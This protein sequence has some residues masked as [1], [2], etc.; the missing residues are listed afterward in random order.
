MFNAAPATTSLQ[1]FIYI[2]YSDSLNP[3]FGSALMNEE[4]KQQKQH[5]EGSLNL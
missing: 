2:A 5:Y 1:E 4:K 3:W